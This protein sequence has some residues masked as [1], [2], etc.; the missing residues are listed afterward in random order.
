MWNQGYSL[1]ESFSLFIFL[2]LEAVNNSCQKN[3][4]KKIKLNF[5]TRGAC[6]RSPHVS[7]PLYTCN[8]QK[9]RKEMG[10]HHSINQCVYIY[11]YILS[12]LDTVLYHIIESLRWVVSVD[13]IMADGCFS[14]HGTCTSETLSLTHTHSH[15]HTLSL[16]NNRYLDGIENILERV[17]INLL[18]PYQIRPLKTNGPNPISP[19]PNI[20]MNFLNNRAL[21]GLLGSSQWTQSCIVPPPHLKLKV[22]TK[23]KTCYI[24][25]IIY[26]SYKW[27]NLKCKLNKYFR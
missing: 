18:G 1:E 7:L 17:T 12:K 5:F 8:T 14:S 11:I 26:N 24:W 9:K 20:V 10:D 6:P 16:L 25:W 3:T 13:Q 2:L 27:N 21:K 19:G 4:L 23:S 15:T 22:R